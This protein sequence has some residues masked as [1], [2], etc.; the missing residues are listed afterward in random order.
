MINFIKVMIWGNLAKT[1][2]ETYGW[3]TWLLKVLYET[4]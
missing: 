4:S 2:K 1:V 3:E